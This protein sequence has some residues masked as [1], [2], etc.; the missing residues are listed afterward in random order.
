MA[1]LT[2]VKSTTASWTKSSA[3]LVVF[4]IFKDQTMTSTG[5]EINKD[6]AEMLQNDNMP[7]VQQRPKAVFRGDTWSKVP[8]SQIKASGGDISGS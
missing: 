3:D 1:F 7:V 8:H 2:Y 5:N 4:G 6:Y